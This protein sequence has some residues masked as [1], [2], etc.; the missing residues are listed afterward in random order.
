MFSLRSKA[1]S[2]AKRSQSTNSV[3]QYY[4]TPQIP[5]IDRLA[6]DG[7]PGLLSKEGLEN[8]WYK[9]A[10]LYCDGLNKEIAKQSLAAHDV[11]VLV[12]EYAKSPSKVKLF[13]NA[14][15]LSNTE[16]AISSL[17]KVR[18]QDNLPPKASVETLL[19]TPDINKS[20]ENDL[21]EGSFRD[22]LQDSFGSII[23]F[24]TLLLNSANAINGDGFTWVVARKPK[25]STFTTDL[26]S[27]KDEYD[28]LFVLNTYN[29]GTPNNSIR[30]GQLS[31][32]SRK[33]K[34]LETKVNSDGSSSSSSAFSVSRSS[35]L[36]LL[37]ARDSAM[38]DDVEYKPILAI[39]SSPKVWLH[40][41]GVYGK[42]T[43]LE[44][45]WKAID[46]DIVTRRLPTRAQ[47]QIY[48]GI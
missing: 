6:Q 21:P 44:N 1:L 4:K 36:S 5:H 8:A 19:E 22:W 38:Y 7:I 15:L 46:W 3:M 33:I 41:Y 23:E 30:F 10:E 26:S 34:E 31:E 20:I 48:S 14:S 35:I 11:D 32:I 47:S 13:N 28:S 17:G 16:F 9:R 25:R 27:S 18:E 29:A 43:Y 45:V 24:K 42:K 37:E 2:V 12:K 40:D 39:D